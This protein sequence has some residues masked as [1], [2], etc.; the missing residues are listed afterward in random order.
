MVDRSI[1][2]RRFLRGASTAVA[3]GL[4]GCNGSTDDRGTEPEETDTKTDTDTDTATDTDTG[5]TPASDAASVSFVTPND[6]QTVSGGASVVMEAE[7][8]TIEESGAVNENAG[9]FHVLVDTDPVASGEPIPSDDQHVHFGDASTESVLALQ[10]GSHT[11]TLQV[12]D[13]KH[14]AYDVTDS[15]DVAVEEASVQF[16]N[17]D[18]GDTVSSP[19]SLEWATENYTLE[20]AGEVRQGAGHAHLIVDADPVPVGDTIPSDDQ[21]IHFGDGSASAELDIDA[22]EHTVTLQ[23]GNGHHLATPLTDT[24]TLTVE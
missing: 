21:H 17:V 24:V 6:G 13:G 4:A 9:H 1:P 15:V 11:L 23:M 3:L 16:T 18:D 10:P 20:S 14:R 2:R 5:F 19:V 22:G 12:G 7:N 8:F